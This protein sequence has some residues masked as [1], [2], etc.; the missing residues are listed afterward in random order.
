MD[1]KNDFII[2]ALNIHGSFFHKKCIEAISNTENLSV[3]EKEFPVELDNEKTKIDII[4]KN[5]FSNL[6]SYFI[7]EC[8][9]ADNNFKTWVFLPDIKHGLND[10]SVIGGDSPLIID[11]FLNLRNS[12]D[13]PIWTIKHVRY[14][15]EFSTNIYRDINS[16]VCYDA[17]QIKFDYDKEG[18]INWNNIPKSAN[19]KDIEDACNQVLLGTR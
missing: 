16:K 7:I 19:K 9:K 2:D 10:N 6:E 13:P 4:A 15:H 5:Y 18:D 17:Y 8:K 1:A 11:T 3:I 12:L 14:I